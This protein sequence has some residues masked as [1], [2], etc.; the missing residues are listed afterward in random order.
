MFEKMKYLARQ[1]FI[2]LLLPFFL[3]ACQ[4]TTKEGIQ[5]LK[6]HLSLRKHLRKQGGTKTGMNIGEV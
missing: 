5:L 3:W 2:L 1:S 6:T 4:P